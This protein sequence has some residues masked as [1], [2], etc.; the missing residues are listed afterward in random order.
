MSFVGD[1][2]DE[3]IQKEMAE[4]VKDL[5]ANVSNI[6]VWIYIRRHTVRRNNM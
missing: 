4:E 1:L 5:E 2:L 6:S 3:T